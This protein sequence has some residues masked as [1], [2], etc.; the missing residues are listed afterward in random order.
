MIRPMAEFA[1]K[2]ATVVITM[3]AQANTKRAVVK[4]W[5]GARY[6]FRDEAWFFR[7]NTNSE[8]AVRPKEMKST[9]IT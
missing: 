9:E 6:S 2:V 5:P 3:A 8:A 4:G 7:R 1:G